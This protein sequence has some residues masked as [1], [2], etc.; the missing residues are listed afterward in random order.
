MLQVWENQYTLDW[1][2]FATDEVFEYRGRNIKGMK[3]PRPVLQKLY[4]D[5]A[6]RWIPGILPARSQP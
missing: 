6:I 4:H 1:R 5:N 3:L 2:F